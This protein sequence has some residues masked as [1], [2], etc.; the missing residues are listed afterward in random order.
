MEGALT[1]EEIESFDDDVLLTER[2]YRRLFDRYG[3][4]EPPGAGLPPAQ[5][6]FVAAT[7]FEYDTLNGGVE[8]YVTSQR[9]DAET[10]LALAEDGLRWIGVHGMA[11]VAA[12]AR[13]IAI[14]ER[15]L[16]ERI[17]PWNGYRQFMEYLAQT[18]LKDLDE[19]LVDAYAERAAFVRAH[20][21]EFTR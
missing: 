4:T 14:Q 6:A 17:Q 19:R 13:R 3:V 18:A 1:V 20:A 15:P 8:Q 5:R 12:D 21:T 7:W 9:P 10:A 2:V 11:E 16:R